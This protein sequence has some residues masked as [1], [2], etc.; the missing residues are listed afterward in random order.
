MMAS[1]HHGMPEW[2]VDTI[3]VM[4]ILYTVIYAAEAAIKIWAMRF[5]PY[6]SVPLNAMDFGTTLISLS[7][8]AIMLT[9]IQRG[10]LRSLSAAL[11]LRVLRLLKIMRLVRVL[12]ELLEVCF[13]SLTA[14]GNLWLFTACSFC[15]LLGS[16]HLHACKYRT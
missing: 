3:F 13:A 7:S 1:E 11:V 16:L 5:V 4:D 2:L 9:G 14:L 6:I 10:S 15:I 8:Y 12:R